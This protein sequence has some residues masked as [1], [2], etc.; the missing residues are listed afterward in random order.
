MPMLASV[1]PSRRTLRS[2]SNSRL[3]TKSLR[4]LRSIIALS[5]DLAYSL[6]RDSGLGLLNSA[7]SVVGFAT[8]RATLR[9][10]LGLLLLESGMCR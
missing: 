5:S 8:N 9:K 6:S 4:R 2:M 3:R 1:R 7:Q 10:K